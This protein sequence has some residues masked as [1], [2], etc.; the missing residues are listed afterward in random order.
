MLVLEEILPKTPT[1]SLDYA[2]AYKS[3]RPWALY[4]FTE[5]KKEVHFPRGIIC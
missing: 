1:K 2:D 3:K 5:D 4:Y